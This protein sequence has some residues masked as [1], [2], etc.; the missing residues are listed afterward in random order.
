MPVSFGRP[1]APIGAADPARP[2]AERAS[3]GRAER[4]GGLD[5]LVLQQRD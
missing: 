1:P 4:L 5:E 3:R 2:A